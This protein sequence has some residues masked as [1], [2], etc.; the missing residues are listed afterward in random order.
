MKNRVLFLAIFLIILCG[1]IVSSLHVGAVSFSLS[2]LR[3]IFSGNTDSIE[4]TIFWNLR[5]PRVIAAIAVGGSLA[6]AGVVMQAVF[7]NPLVEPYT[8]G[9]SGSAS[10]GIALSYLLNLPAMLGSW[11]IPAGAFIGA[12]PI[13]LFLLR[14]G[15]VQRSSSKGILLSGVMLSYICSSLVTL[16]LTVVDLETMGSIVQWGFGS[17]AGVTL[18]GGAILLVVSIVSLVILLFTALQLNALSLSE[19]DALSLGVPLHRLRALLLVIATV[20]TAGAVSVGGVIGFVGLLVPHLVRMF[21]SNDNRFLIPFSWIVG[22]GL[23]LGADTF[24]RVVIL[25]REIPVGV[26][27]GIVGGVLFL[28]LLQKRENSFG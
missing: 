12:V 10:L 16:I 9:L 18:K 22:A 20:L 4:F 23:L 15:V 6:L 2:D 21:V 26:I 28:F 13:L 14:S 24:G 17:L 8:L 11:V 1:I 27:S 19:S 3:E 7:A 5:L 25:P